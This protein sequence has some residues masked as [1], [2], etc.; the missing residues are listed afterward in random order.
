MVAV[1]STMQELGSRAPQFDLPD[2]SDDDKLIS[3][4]TFAGQPLLVMFICNHCPFVVHIIEELTATANHFQRQGF[5]VVAISANDIEN[6]PQDGPGPMR[7]F[8]QQHGFQFAYCYDQSQQVA[9][10]YGAACTPD[11]FVYDS[12]H[13]L[14][15]RGQFDA[16]RPSNAVV[17]DG[18]DLREAM[19]ALLDGD[20][21]TQEQRPSIGCN[22]K[23][24]A[25]NEP[26][27][28]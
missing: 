5:G 19:Q 17:V 26:D 4:Q 23:W 14:R 15:Y 28:F 3:L 16:A 6:Y 8:A 11:F 24:R 25:G 7:E 12:H 18:A 10:E 1:N 2:V 21:V 20:E 9:I 13:Q 22:I 27:Y